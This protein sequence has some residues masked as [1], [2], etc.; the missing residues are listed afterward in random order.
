MALIVLLPQAELMVVSTPQLM[1]QK[2]ATRVADMAKE[3][4][5]HFE[6]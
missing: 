6:V 2:V 5:Y 1:A 4:L 3:V